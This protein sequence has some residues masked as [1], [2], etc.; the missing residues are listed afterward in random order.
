M[1]S[2]PDDVAARLAFLRSLQDRGDD[3]TYRLI[4]RI[5]IHR[6]AFHFDELERRKTDPASVII[7]DAEEFGRAVI[8]VSVAYGGVLDH[9]TASKFFQSVGD[10]VRDFMMNL[11]MESVADG[12]IKETGK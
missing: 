7:A 12:T 3:V 8:A 1:V 10:G 9:D 5:A 4:E 11:F 2:F 6:N